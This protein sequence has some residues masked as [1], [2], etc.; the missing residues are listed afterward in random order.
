MRPW[1]AFAALM[2]VT[3]SAAGCL[4]DPDPQPGGDRDG[5]PEAPPAPG[6]GPAPSSRELTV[7]LTDC[8][9]P[10]AFAS[11]PADQARSHVPP[12][13]DLALD[14]SGSAAVVLGGLVCGEQGGLAQR[15]LLA[16]L[17][18]PNDEALLADG[19]ENYFWEPEHQLV[20]G[21]A[22][23]DAF[24]EVGANATLVSAVTATVMPVG[25]TLV[26]DASTWQHRIS[27]S[28]GAWPAGESAFVFGHFREYALGHGGYVYL[29][30]SFD[31]PP[32]STAGG[33]L[34]TVETGTGTIARELLGSTT[35]V[36][37]LYGDGLVYA[38][39]RVGFIPR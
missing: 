5:E 11:V 38:D 18:T 20:E 35:S 8:M 15:G 23:T 17:V 39:A 3:A 27:G 16:I 7:A 12:D 29:D 30:A 24:L 34:A 13:F 2:L 4:S 26:V 14:E 1:I 28:P 32:G 10:E 22:L 25:M 33:T 9:I 37:A 36:P 19:V 21:S 6:D 31:G